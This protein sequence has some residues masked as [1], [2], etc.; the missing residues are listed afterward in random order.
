[1]D[2]LEDESKLPEITPLAKKTKLKA[3]E[4]ASKKKEEHRMTDK[5]KA[6]LAKAR[7][8]RDLKR[9]MRKKEAEESKV[10]LKTLH[11]M[12]GSLH[13]RLERMEKRSVM[14]QKVAPVKM[15]QPVPQ[16]AP[17]RRQSPMATGFEKLHGGGFSF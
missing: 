1:M 16:T 9:S 10:D 4:K 6:A 15:D 3:T 7:A 8:T 12:V 11:G 13:D 2:K 17:V 14:E 5:R